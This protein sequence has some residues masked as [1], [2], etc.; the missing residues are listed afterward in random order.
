MPKALPNEALIGPV[1][2]V[3]S[4]AAESNAC[5]SGAPLF[6]GHPPPPAMQPGAQPMRKLR[7]LMG[8]FYPSMRLDGRCRH[9]NTTIRAI[10]MNRCGDGHISLQPFANYCQTTRALLDHG[11]ARHTQDLLD[12]ARSLVARRPSDGHVG[13]S[14]ECLAASGAHRLGEHS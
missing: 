9:L 6:G 10:D 14:I 8:D 4:A 5:G 13:C 1:E 7:G 2:Q 11:G 12:A 3:H